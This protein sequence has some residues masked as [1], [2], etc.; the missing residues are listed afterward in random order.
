MTDL[1]GASDF[2]NSD[3]LHRGDHDRAFWQAKAIP[4][5]PQDLQLAGKR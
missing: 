1:T 2:S 3:R 4:V 5:L